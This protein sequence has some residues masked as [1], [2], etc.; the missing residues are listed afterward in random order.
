MIWPESTLLG[1]LVWIISILLQVSLCLFL[2]VVGFRSFNINLPI[3]ALVLDLREAILF[4]RFVFSSTAMHPFL[5]GAGVCAL[6]YVIQMLPFLLQ[7]TAIFIAGYMLMVSRTHAPPMSTRRKLMLASWSEPSEGSIHG[8]LH[9]NAEPLLRHLDELRAQ[10]RKVTITT[11][12][13]KAIALALRY[14]PSLNCRII[15][16]TFVPHKTIDVGC[17]VA[18]DDGKDLAVSKISMADK[19]DMNEI[20]E[21]LRSRGEKLRAHK[22]KDF[23][24]SKPMLSLLPVFALR[25]LVHFMGY[26]TGAL[27]VNLPNFGL[28]SF[29]FGSC[30]VTSVG[31]LGIETAFIP[32][33]PWAR[34][35]LLVM[36]GAITKK[37]VVVDDKIIIQQQLSLTFT[38]DHR[39]VDGTEISRVGKILRELLEN[40]I[41]L[42]DNTWHEEKPVIATPAPAPAL[43]TATTITQATKRA[44]SD[45]D[46]EDEKPKSAPA[47]HSA[48]SRR[49][50]ASD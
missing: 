22:D 47:K 31:M 28:R 50:P 25:P 5:L 6:L 39:F 32:F 20:Q 29:P 30:L 26:L 43:V 46:S 19:K 35:P 27:G 11:A 1:E 21:E 42:D 17:L 45:S 14:A 3:P 7:L 13:I 15:H 4:R 16:D 38:L 41:K 18:L 40:P 9:V 34:V 8:L 33:T 48:S 2:V 37:A 36:I 24:S 49:L 10:D 23:E 12:V 44:D